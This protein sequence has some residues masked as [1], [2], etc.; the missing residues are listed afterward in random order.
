MVSLLSLYALLLVPCAMSFITAMPS[1]HSSISSRSSL[2]SNTL[3]QQTR[4]RAEAP[5]CVIISGAPGS[6]KGTQCS[7]IVREFGLVHLSTGDMLRSCVKEGTDIG[8]SAKAFM[9]AGDLVPDDLVVDMVNERLA[10]DDVTANGFLLDGYPRTA[11]QAERLNECLKGS[12]LRVGCFVNLL[13]PDA[14]IVERVC[15]RRIDS[16]T[17]EIYHIKFK[18]P[19][20]SVPA[21]RLT[22]RTDD[23]EEAVRT[24]LENYNRAN[25]AVVNVYKDVKVD[26]D[27]VGE[28]QQVWG[29]V[30]EGIASA[31]NFV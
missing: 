29:R 13:V 11:S 21:D 15:G 24:R 18:P 5:V 31:K 25:A 16:E 3:Q 10:K 8:K 7:N 6:G 20:A 27:G 19:P 23:T 9:D 14:D 30:K 26:V 17:G 12:K 1:S 2:S 28:V 22:H 4:L